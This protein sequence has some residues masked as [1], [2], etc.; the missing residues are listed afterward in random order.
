MNI[1]IF[2]IL[3]N[4]KQQAKQNPRKFCYNCAKIGH[5]GFECP[6]T[7]YSDYAPE[8]PFKTA[9]CN[10]SSQSNNDSNNNIMFISKETANILSTENGN[11]FLR[12]LSDNI[13]LRLEFFRGEQDY[14]KI[15][16][17][18]T[19]LKSFQAEFRKFKSVATDIFNV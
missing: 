8:N 13:K 16:G 18:E 12:F 9:L 4:S 19:K 17:N 3:G 14:I 10:N 2:Q 1:S 15:V 6:L 5:F 11:N 7:P